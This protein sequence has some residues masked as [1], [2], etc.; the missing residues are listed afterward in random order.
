MPPTEHLKNVLNVHKYFI[1]N[2]RGH[3]KKGWALGL[4]NWKRRD[5]STKGRMRLTRHFKNA[6][7]GSKYLIF[8]IQGNGKK[9][10]APKLE[11]EDP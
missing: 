8:N 3:E 7:N 4:R 6:L 9:D 1:F 11:V 5:P 10:Y 2:I